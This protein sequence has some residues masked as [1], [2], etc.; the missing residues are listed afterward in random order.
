ME[1]RKL[2]KYLEHVVC[3]LCGSNDYK[4]IFRSTLTEDDFQHSHAQY[5]ISERGQTCGQIVQC[6]RC[7]LVY[8][9]PRE[10]AQEIIN[11]YTL[12]KD[13]KYVTEEKG[14]RAT[15]LQGL[16]LIEKYSRGKGKLLDIGCFTGFFLDLARQSGWSVLGIESSKWAVDYGRNE[17][18]L[19]VLQGTL[20]DFDFED[21]VFDVVTMWD[22]IEHL[23]DPKSTLLS[24]N[25]KLK[26]GGILF[27]NTVNYDS[28]FGKLLRRKF[29]F[30][31]R[32]HIYYFSSQT[33]R[34]ML[35]ECNYE[36]IK[37][38]LHFKT[39]SLGYLILRFRE[40][41]NYLAN[42]IDFLSTLFLLKKW[43]VTVYVGQMTII[44]KKGE[45]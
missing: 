33:I 5:S 7:N 19:G 14:R 12:V 16:N 44:A 34:R 11:N 31:E 38:G 27:L 8:V 24:L 3:N 41:N 32:M 20:E 6:Q 26:R 37:I 36:V 17:L 4:V 25:K 9:N 22:V 28:I 10:K 23:P 42:I 1:D 45:R 35:K 18:S 39:L 2:D 21:E 15:F 40:V 30:I 29:W 13:E 43:N